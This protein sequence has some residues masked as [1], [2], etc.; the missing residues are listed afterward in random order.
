MF[1]TI[2]GEFAAALLDAEKPVPRAVTSHTSR[3]PAKRFGVYR[4]NVVAGL[5]NALRSQFPVVEKIVGKDFFAATARV[6]AI[7]HPPQSPLLMHYGAAFADFIATFEPASVL[8]YLPD[9]ARL[10]IARTRAYHAADAEPIDPARLQGLDRRE[11][12]H[13][14][15][16]LHPSAQILRSRHPIV[17]IWAMNSGEAELR[18]IVDEGAEDALVVRPRLE[19]TVRRLPPGGGAFLEALSAGAAL[20]IA[21]ESAA[22]DCAQFDLTATLAG[23]IGSGAMIDFVIH[24]GRRDRVA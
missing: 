6:Y 19:V 3:T 2:Q 4:N 20:A 12:R 23:L 14:R 15:V 1:A 5:V 9:I 22:A 13:I 8:P 16:T 11:L 18:P 10:E 21:A 17:T 7:A 24:G